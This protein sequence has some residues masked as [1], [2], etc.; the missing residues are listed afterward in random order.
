MGE[1]EARTAVITGGGRGFGEA[2]GRAL[3]AEGAHAVLVDVDGPAAKA[4]A[5]TIRSEGGSAEG[6]EGDVTDEARMA[7]V[8]AHASEARGG[9]DLLINNA[10]LH[11]EEYSK[12]IG[13][14]GLDKVRRL[15]DVNVMGVVTCTLAAWPHMRGARGR[16]SSTSARRQRTSAPPRTATASSRS[17]GSRSRSP[18]S[19]GPTASA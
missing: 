14:M 4:A 1:W 6:L 10:G 5:E 17:R 11:S 19:S 8:M 13:V 2:F 16:A 12:P 3:A 15:F 7:E 18:A 9:I